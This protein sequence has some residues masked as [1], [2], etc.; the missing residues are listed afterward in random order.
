MLEG[1]EVLLNTEYQEFIKTHSNIARKIIFTGMIDE[2]F[3]YKL[4]HLEYRTVRFEDELLDMEDYQGNAVVNYTENVVTPMQ[5][6][7]LE[8]QEKRTI[9][10]RLNEFYGNKRKT[11]QSLGISERTLHRKLKEYGM[12]D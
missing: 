6:I 8:E 7:T 10:E 9:I 12:N 1:S 3:D 2:Y 5:N 11:A 4:G